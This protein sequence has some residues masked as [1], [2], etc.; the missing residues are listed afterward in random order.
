VA[1]AQWQ[2]S[3]PLS[4]IH[5]QIK[6][7]LFKGSSSFPTLPTRLTVNSLTCHSLGVGGEEGATIDP[8]FL[9]WIIIV[10]CGFYWNSVCFYLLSFELILICSGINSLFIGVKKKKNFFR[11]PQYFRGGKVLRIGKV[12]PRVRTNA[13]RIH[14]SCNKPLNPS[15]GYMFQEFR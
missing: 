3:V 8:E 14:K 7:F 13:F 6:R 2:H 15:F 1:G 5:L 10:A 9:F 11:F 4:P 12:D